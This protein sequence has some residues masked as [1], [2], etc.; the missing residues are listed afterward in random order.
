[1]NIKKIEF[2]FNEMLKKIKL[3]EEA[4]SQISSLILEKSFLENQLLDIVDYKT[5]INEDKYKQLLQQCG[6]IYDSVEQK[7]KISFIG[8]ENIN[9]NNGFYVDGENG[10]CYINPISK[11]EIKI[12]D[13]VLSKD[14][15]TIKFNFEKYEIVNFLYFEFYKNNGNSQNLNNVKI[16]GENIEQI[17]SSYDIDITDSFIKNFDDNYKKDDFSK[18]LL[19][20]PK[21]IKSILFTFEDE[22][23][24]NNYKVNFSTYEYNYIDEKEII[25]KI[26]NN[27]SIG[28]FKF[29]K[30]DYNK[31]I[32]LKYY[33]SYD[34]ITY[35]EFNFEKNIKNEKYK[36]NEAVVIANEKT[37]FE[38]FFIKITNGE[39][40]NSINKKQILRE[41]ERFILNFSNSTTY[42]ISE[43]IIDDS[44]FFIIPDAFKIAIDKESVM[45]EVFVKMPNGY[46][47]NN[48]FLKIVDKLNDDTKQYVTSTTYEDITLKKK[49]F[50]IY[51]EKD[52][53]TFFFPGYVRD[54]YLQYNYIEE[55]TEIENKFYTPIIFDLTIKNSGGEK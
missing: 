15:K 9:S 2:L 41:K 55:I 32:D 33:F 5:K 18:A 48:Y 45:P 20:N 34:G 22:V 50:F 49:K 27:Y 6:N 51:Y 24:I 16:T 1:M 19:I 12:K 44:I 46:M 7:T 30:T 29:N 40:K 37:E 17:N 35:N 8:E 13:Y 4:D 53:K 21:N 42:Q 38:N 31:I 11:T 36:T 39:F 10:I 28:D 52:T 3:S 23:D 14:K 54:I 25:L 43:E 26:K 47:I